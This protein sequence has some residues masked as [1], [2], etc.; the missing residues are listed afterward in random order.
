M[1]FT[2]RAITFCGAPFQNASATQ[3]IGNSVTDLVLRLSGPTTP[4]WQRHQA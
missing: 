3:Q 2:Y 1:C 4:A